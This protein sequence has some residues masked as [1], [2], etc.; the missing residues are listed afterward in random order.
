MDK[1]S[2]PVTGNRAAYLSACGSAPELVIVQ[3]RCEYEV[4]FNTIQKMDELI[5]EKFPWIFNPPINSTTS[6]FVQRQLDMER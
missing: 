2:D 6:S 5:Y 4:K 1:T 3:V